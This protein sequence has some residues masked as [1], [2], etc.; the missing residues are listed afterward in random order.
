[1]VNNTLKS[2][3]YP[4]NMMTS[5]ACTY[6]VPIP[7]GTVMQVYFQEFSL[8]ATDLGGSCWYVNELLNRFKQI[9]GMGG[10]Q[11]IQDS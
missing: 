3:F 7:P 8:G 4:S 10:F 6:Y 9:K 2:P 5:A 11:S 1:M